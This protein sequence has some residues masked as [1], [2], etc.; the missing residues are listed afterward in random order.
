MV[1][2]TSG[3][4]SLG[5]VAAEFGGTPPYKM[6]EYYPVSELYYWIVP[7]IGNPL[8]ITHFYGLANNPLPPTFQTGSN[9]GIFIPNSSFTFS[10]S[11]SS[12]SPVTLTLTSGSAFGSFSATGGTATI[13]GTTPNVSRGNYSWT[14]Q[15]ED[16]E[17]QITTRTFNML[18]SQPPSWSQNLS[19]G[20]KAAGSSVS[21]ALSASS[22]S[23]LTYT[24]VSFPPN[25]SSGSISGTTFSATVPSTTG[26]RTWTIRVTDEEGQYVDKNLSIHSVYYGYSR[27][28]IP[29]Y[30]YSSTANGGNYYVYGTFYSSNDLT[31]YENGGTRYGTVVG[32]QSS[33][34]YSY[35]RADHPEAQFEAGPRFSG[36]TYLG[37][38]D[39]SFDRWADG[40]IDW[41]Y[42]WTT[43]YTYYWTQ[44]YIYGYTYTT[45]YTQ[46]QQTVYGT[47]YSNND[48]FVYQNGAYRYGY[49]DSSSYGIVQY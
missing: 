34:S 15:A 44:G 35:W 21:Q 42:Y 20:Y 19:L 3:P 22:D 38:V 49:V 11:A 10:V 5:N 2:Q 31:R 16:A 33:S 13:T 28:I 32:S 29:S 14:I 46:P 17:R 41:V 1:I 43:D 37:D 40:W 27:G 25:V 9:M 26:S 30:S 48:V 36:S 8:R 47:Y 24:I 12:D 45:T 4:I 23:T 6:S 18:V 7:S 39:A